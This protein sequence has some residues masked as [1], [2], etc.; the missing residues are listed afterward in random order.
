MTRRTLVRS[1]G[2]IGLVAA[3]AVSAVIG[4]LKWTAAR[5][6]E[7]ADG[8]YA[9]T[10]DFRHYT[11]SVRLRAYGDSINAVGEKRWLIEHISR[12]ESKVDDIASCQRHPESCR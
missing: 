10:T 12:L 7:A 4:G 8:T 3:A 2:I 11:D 9:H 5:A 6:F 1:T